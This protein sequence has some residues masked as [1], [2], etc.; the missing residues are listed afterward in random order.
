M[1]ALVEHLGFENFAKNESVNF[2]V[3]KD[4]GFMNTEGRFIRKGKIN[5][6]KKQQR[7]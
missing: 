2:E 5:I 3:G 7:K 1:T 4:L 6:L